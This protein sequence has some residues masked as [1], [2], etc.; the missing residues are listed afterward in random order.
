MAAVEAAFQERFG[1][2]AGWAHNTLFISE[3][4]TQRHLLP[5]HLQPPVPLSLSEKTPSFDFLGHLLSD[6]G[7]PLVLVSVIYAICV[8]HLVSLCSLLVT[9]SVWGKACRVGELDESIRLKQGSTGKQSSK[10]KKAKLAEA[11]VQGA[12]AADFLPEDSAQDLC[13]D[14]QGDLLHLLSCGV[15]DSGSQQ[16]CIA[17]IILEILLGSTQHVV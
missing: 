10:A 4:A 2:H 17:S 16:C 6:A 13:G 11:A 5:E 1:S 3:L 12:L 9:D 7:H 14:A 15:Y 8:R